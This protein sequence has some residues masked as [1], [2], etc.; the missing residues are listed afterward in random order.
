MIIPCASGVWA[1]VS[2]GGQF[3]AGKSHFAFLRS[4]IVVSNHR[5][6]N[7]DPIVLMRCSE[8]LS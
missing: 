6:P 4:L 3:V 7:S 8:I 1:A 5:V 2:T